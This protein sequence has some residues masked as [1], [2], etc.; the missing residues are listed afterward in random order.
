MV[1]LLIPEE[2]L[3][4]RMAELMKNK[5]KD[6]DNWSFEKRRHFIKSLREQVEKEFFK[7]PEEDSIFDELEA[8]V[9]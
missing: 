9:N 2:I 4:K 8:M 1:P 3:E 6:F 7:D 5:P